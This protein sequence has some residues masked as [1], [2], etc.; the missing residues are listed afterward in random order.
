ML[1]DKW[2]RIQYTHVN[3]NIHNLS[4]FIQNKHLSFS[5][6]ICVKLTNENNNSI[7]SE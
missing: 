2:L 3:K 5:S 7:D 6:I 4:K 1:K